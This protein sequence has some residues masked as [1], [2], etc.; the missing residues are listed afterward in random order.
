MSMELAL[1]NGNIGQ[2]VET[3]G[4]LADQI[5]NTDFVPKNM[6]GK[7]A[8]VLAC[9]MYGAEL[10]L[11]PLQSLHSIQSVE[12]A[13]GMKP[14][15]MRGHVAANGHRIWPSEYTHERVTMCGWRKGDPADAVV[16]V[17]WTM[18]DAN[19][20][21]LGGKDVWKKYPRAMLLARAT[22]ELCRLHFA[23]VIGGLSYTPEEM[24]DFGDTPPIAW[25]APIVADRETGEIL[26]PPEPVAI[27]AAPATSRR[28]PPP[29]AAPV[30]DGFVSAA[31][32][33]GRLV[34]AYKAQGLTQESAISCAAVIWAAHD[35]TSEPISV[36]QLDR[37]LS[38][39]DEEPR[40]TPV[41]QESIDAANAEAA[42]APF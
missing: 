5:A 1:A 32:A 34:E 11:G 30:P 15:G 12:G 2:T 26:R 9:M 8:A 27:A 38:V 21:G 36:E 14:E 19:K 40:H 16:S 42:D 23:D 39:M 7:P 37:V 28:R 33:K 29:G 4:R 20:A 17:T 24:E 3:F 31:Q 35:L 13:V 41:P 18:A 25:S 6:R 22:S 10:G